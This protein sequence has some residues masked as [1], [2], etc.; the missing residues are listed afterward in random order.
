[1]KEAYIAD[2]TPPWFLTE[3]TDFA[4]KP[5]TDAEK[6]DT[7]KQLL[8]HQEA[9]RNVKKLH[10]AGFLI[11]TGTDAPYPGVFQ[12]EALH[13]ELELLVTAGWKPLEAI[14]A[15]T[16]DAARLMKADNEWGSVQAG[17]RAT[18]LVVAGEPGR[19]DQRH[20]Q[21]RNLGDGRKNCEPRHA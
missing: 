7:Q 21:D 17:R 13:H 12:G 3:L 10:D 2:T 6:K 11:A 5:Q 20:A 8:E 1:M 9:M 15:S 18:L 19:A 14:R 4:N 16:Y